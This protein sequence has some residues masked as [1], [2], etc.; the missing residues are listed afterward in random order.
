MT[1]DFISK[2]SLV[3]RYVDRWCDWIDGK[4]VEAEPG[5]QNKLESFK[6]RYGGA[7]GCTALKTDILLYRAEHHP[8]IAD[9]KCRSLKLFD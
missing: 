6:V 8:R 5:M 7:S 1:S 9:E 2:C 4:A 3:G